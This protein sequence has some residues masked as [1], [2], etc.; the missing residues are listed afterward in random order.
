MRVGLLFAFECFR[1]EISDRDAWT[2]DL[3]L[4]S[5][6]EPLG[7][8]VLAVTEHHFFNYNV[9]PTPVEL[10]TY[11]AGRTSRI[12]LLTAAVILPWND[13]MRVVE[14]M[15]TLD[16]LSNGRAVLGMG[17]GLAKR[18]YDAFGID[19]SETRERFD[20][21]AEIILRGLETGIVEADGSFYKQARVEVR[22]R[23]LKSF[24][25]RIGCVSMSSDSVESCARLGAQ[26]IIFGQKSIEDMLA[27]ITTYRES[28]LRHHG[29]KAPPIMFAE[30]LVCHQDAARAEELAY[31]HMGNLHEAVMEHYDMGGSHFRNI[32]GYSDYANS[33]DKMKG[34]A[35][36]DAAVQFTKVNTFGTPKQIIDQ[37]EH[38]RELIG[39]FDFMFQSCIGGMSQDTAENSIRVFAEHVLPVLQSWKPAA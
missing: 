32:K 28:F 9:S 33:A 17:R 22:P 6:A 10:L 11:F 27:P 2:R 7:F 20:E 31:H 8:D 14:K 34:V 5:L 15:I 21:A 36:S 38:R 16:Y 24:K 39:E 3:H 18:E 26:M 4:A 13:P 19:M 23:P 25:D 35:A 37:L 29:R 12:E 1:D 30:I